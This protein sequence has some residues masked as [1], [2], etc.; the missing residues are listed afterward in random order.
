MS[1]L[2][3]AI[4]TTEKYAVTADISIAVLFITAGGIFDGFF[5]AMQ[6]FIIY[7][8][9]CMLIGTFSSSNPFGNH[10]KK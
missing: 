7:M 6:G 9:V 8:L 2:K 10:Q 3:D 4:K 5:G 1:K